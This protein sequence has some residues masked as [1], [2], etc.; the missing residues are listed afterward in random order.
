[1]E[2][3]FYHEKMQFNRNGSVVNRLSML[4]SSE[5]LEPHVVRLTM[6][7]TLFVS[8]ERTDFESV[9][10]VLKDCCVTMLISLPA[11]TR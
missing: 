4:A 1:M 3:Y 6:N 7:T 2:G 5:V 9:K 10:V 8:E 11:Y